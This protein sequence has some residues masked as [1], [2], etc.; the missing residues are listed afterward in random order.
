MKKKRNIEST[1][2]YIDKSKECEKCKH[3]SVHHIG[4]KMISASNTERP[5]L[6]G[7]FWIIT[8]VILSIIMAIVLKSIFRMDEIIPIT[9]LAIFSYSVI[10]L[11]FIGGVRYIKKGYTKE[12]F[13][14]IRRKSLIVFCCIII[15]VMLFAYLNQ[16]VLKRESFII[17][18]DVK[19]LTLEQELNNNYVVIEKN[20]LVLNCEYSDFIDLWEAVT[21]DDKSTFHIKYEWNV[22]T[23]NK[24]RLTEIKVID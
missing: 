6:L 18:N 4:K 7:W 3:D 14:R 8:A 13:H 16:S 2:D 10:L 23:P 15:F 12:I 1:Y 20:D 9:V 21:T 17:I 5:K 24:G 19:L 11:Q 22:L